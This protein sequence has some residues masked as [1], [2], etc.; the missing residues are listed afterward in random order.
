MG[1]FFVEV[2]WRKFN[3][4]KLDRFCINFMDKFRKKLCEKYFAEN[5]GQEN[6]EK[7]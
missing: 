4:K 1:I 5:F 6:S 2:L 3:K 7:T